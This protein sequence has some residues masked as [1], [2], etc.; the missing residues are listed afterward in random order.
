MTP[1]RVSEDRMTGRSM[2]RAWVILL[3]ASP[4]AGCTLAAGIFKAGFWAGVILAVVLL[5]SVRML[6]RGRR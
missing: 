2:V 6:F 1:D 5:V 3:L 4:A